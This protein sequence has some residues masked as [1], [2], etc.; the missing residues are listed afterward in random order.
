MDLSKK[1]VT[2]PYEDTIL[3]TDTEVEQLGRRLHQQL[4]KNELFLN[5]DLTLRDV[6]EALDSTEK[7]VSY[8]L[9]QKLQTTF[10]E[11]I[12]TYRVEKFKSEVVKPQNKNLS[13]LGI[14]LNCGFPSKSSFYRAF[15][16]HVAMSPS[17][18]IKKISQPH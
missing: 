7:K 18:Y 14:A 11:L 17:E 12:N 1:K 3:L 8:L 9:N 6:A 5:A 13:I 15:K 2:I 16:S 4:N 10:Y